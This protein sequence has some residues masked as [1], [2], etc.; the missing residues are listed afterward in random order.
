MGSALAGEFLDALFCGLSSSLNSV[1]AAQQQELAVQQA[2]IAKLQEQFQQLVRARGRILGLYAL[3]DAGAGGGAQRPLWDAGSEARKKSTGN[4]V[5]ARAGRQVMGGLAA[6]RR[7]AAHT[8][9]R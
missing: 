7:R 8:C 6:R 4:A 3:L 1:L 2:E 9:Q 5:R